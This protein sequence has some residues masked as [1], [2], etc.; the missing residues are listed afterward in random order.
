M[1][2]REMRSRRTFAILSFILSIL[3]MTGTASASQADPLLSMQWDLHA[4]GSSAL[5]EAGLDGSG[6]VVAVIDS[7]LWPY[8]EDLAGIKI[9]P[10]SRNFLGDGSHPESWDRDQTGH[11]SAVAGRIAASSGNGRGIASMAPGTEIMVLRCAS[12]E[13]S[14]LFAYD[15]AYDSGGG[16]MRAVSDALR[17][18]ADH[19]ADVI[20]IS[21]GSSDR[22][23]AAISGAVDHAAAMGC[24]VI[25]SVGNG[26]D[27]MNSLYYPAACPGVIGV[28]SVGSGLEVSPFSQRNESV[29][30]AAPGQKVLGVSI[31]PDGFQL[32]EA[33]IADGYV[34]NEGTSFSAPFVSALAAAAKQA[35]PYI[36]NKG[37]LSLLAVTSKDLG[38][39]G[40]DADCGYGLI[41]CGAFV[42]ALKGPFTVS[43][44]SRG[45]ARVPDMTCSLSKGLSGLSSI[46][47]VR[48]GYR[49]TGWYKDPGCAGEPL[50]AAKATDL[51]SF[52]RDQKN[53]GFRI[54]PLVLYAGW[55]ADGTPAPASVR[56]RGVQA[57]Q[58]GRTFR[59]V[60]PKG[61]LAGREL[62]AEDISV[63]ASLPGMEIDVT[64][65]GRAAVIRV[66]GNGQST[67]F[68][69]EAVESS[70]GMPAVRP[71]MSGV[72]GTAVLGSSDGLV[73]AVPYTADL[74][75][76]F[77]D[78]TSDYRID[79][80][81]GSGDAY[82][83]DGVLSYV[84]GGFDREG[85][86]V[87]ISVRGSNRD[88][89]PAEAA[90]AFRIDLSRAQ[91]NTRPVS[92]QAWFD[93]YR[94][95]D[96]EISL[97]LY[98]NALKEIRL[99]G[100]QVPGNNYLYTTRGGVS[101]LV[102]TR[103]W[104]RQIP[105][106]DHVMTFVSTGGEDCGITLHV[107]DSTPLY[108]ADFYI[109]SDDPYVYT[110]IEGLRKGSAIG[111]LP[112]P[113]ELGEGFS[114]WYRYGD[115]GMV[116][117][118]QK[119]I[120]TGN[121]KICAVWYGEA[122]KDWYIPFEDV[123]QSVPFRRAVLWAYNASPRVAEGVSPSLFG[124]ELECTR[125]QAVTMLWRACGCPE[126]DD[127]E[128]GFSDVA[129]DDYWFKAVTWAVQRGVTDG[130]SQDTFG[131]GTVCTRAQLITFVHR[132]LGLEEG[133]GADWHE[134]SWKWAREKNYSAAEGDPEDAC[135]RA[136]AAELLYRCFRR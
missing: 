31:C 89:A 17:Y 28:G 12:D 8:H 85:D 53:G 106:G 35:C 111:R 27:D 110:S 118:D 84:P 58:S 90:A 128:T 65:A 109:D 119:T 5:S 68:T 32:P 117:I 63:S 97:R 125:A 59:A 54:C 56:V 112:D 21:M 87:L 83:R 71:A 126:P 86:S 136:D 78:Y 20:N 55:E 3:I 127:E 115:G 30:I 95:M 50:S 36:D 79:T 99:D 121:M 22:S 39:A 131:P 7:G 25:A 81:S 13:R 98:D 43:F 123:P 124:P 105:E 1:Q 4:V 40:K 57:V 88:L 14:G 61:S 113:S 108:R 77:N 96:P 116:R 45:G 129:E 72:R 38:P 101:E 60:F 49:F 70:L 80:C 130:L 135:T 100:I 75:L 47:P 102:F 29:D 42:K 64:A 66:F 37:F 73:R 10:L 114:G 120:V 2:Y 67:V 26:S 93:L 9:S 23:F 94:A 74:S 133:Q 107:T 52:E 19:G 103:A 122:P 46:I 15:P 91:S 51:L 16:S 69:A 6:T 134:E 18:A 44:D 92:D 48:S 62:M 41:D 104:L 24:I 33:P 76:V 82:I 11:G 132:A 34:E